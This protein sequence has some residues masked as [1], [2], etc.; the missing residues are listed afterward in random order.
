ML[1]KRKQSKL[2]EEKNLEL[3]NDIVVLFARTLQSIILAVLIKFLGLNEI[4]LEFIRLINWKVVDKENLL[5]GF[6]DAFF[7]KVIKQ[8]LRAKP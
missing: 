7:S 1:R 4:I 5:A 8:V 6:L 2:R 3:R